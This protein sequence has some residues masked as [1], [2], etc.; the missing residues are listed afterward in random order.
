M[1]LHST[2]PEYIEGL[3]IK[4]QAWMHEKGVLSPEFRQAS[5]DYFIAVAAHADLLEG[6]SK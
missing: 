4:A 5:D 1:S 3:R 2:H 6:V